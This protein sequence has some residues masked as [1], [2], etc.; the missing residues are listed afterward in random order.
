MI[1]YLVN[2]YNVGAGLDRHTQ[3]IGG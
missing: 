1:T 3:V 2:I